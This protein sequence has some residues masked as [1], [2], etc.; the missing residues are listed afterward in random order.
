MA[1]EVALKY[2]L[3]E[4]AKSHLGRGEDDQAIQ[5]LSIALNENFFDE[6]ALFILGACLQAKG[7]NGLGAVVTSAAIDARLANGN[8]TFPEALLNLG[9]CYRAEH[10]NETAE[11]IWWDAV[12]YETL[13]EER[14]KILTN[15]SGLYINE[16]DPERALELCA[17]ALKN[18]PN[19]LGA[20]CNRGMAHL[21]LGHWREGWED[22]KNTLKTGDRTARQYPGVPVWDGSPGKRVIVWGDQGVGDEI[23]FSSCIPD[24]IRV[25]EHVV[26]D[27][28]PRLPALF[29]RSFSGAEVYGTRKDVTEPAWW[30]TAKVDAA[31]G[32]AELPGFFRNEDKAW[33]GV[34]YLKAPWNVSNVRRLRIGLSWTGGS[35]KTRQELRSLPVEALA[36]IV[37]AA[38]DADWFSLQYTDDAPADVCRLEE[39]TGIRIAHFA[40]WVQCLDYDRT[41][42]FVASLD[43]VITVCTTV[44]HLAGALGIPVWTLVPKRSSWR[45]GIE[46]DCL[47]WYN[48]ARLFRQAKDGDWAGPIERVA[49]ALKSF[50]MREAAE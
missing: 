35:K 1:D 38:P 45:Y 5:K 33:P 6:E 3:L 16:G 39:Q 18:D 47:P 25:C 14:A 31:I 34:P 40:N 28:H 43:L 13:P 12:R 50:G 8:R 44:H 27:C 7:M 37:R 48:C 20:L 21:E 41:A 42:S 32:M 17:D 10:R 2:S 30:K 49:Y 46:G 36:P 26:I 4:Q 22:W 9:G 15:I 19:C 11:R 24:L 29:A 23:Y